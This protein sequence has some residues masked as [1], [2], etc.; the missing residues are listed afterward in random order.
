MASDDP[1]AA[2]PPR[3]EPPPGGAPSPDPGGEV[4]EALRGIA[5]RIDQLLDPGFRLLDHAERRIIEPVWRRVTRGEPRWPV[6]VAI[7]VAA[8]LQA[9]VPEWL[10]FGPRWLVPTMEGLAVLG[11]VAANP[12]RIDEESR[13][14]RSATVVL[15]GLITFGNVWSAGHLVQDLMSGDP[16]DISARHLLLTGAAI[17]LTNVIAFALWYWELDRGG[18]ASRAH[19]GRSHPDFLFPQMANPDLAPADW[20][21]QFVDYL[22]VSF[23]NATA[24]SP[25]DVVPLARWAKLT[26]LVQSLVSLTTLALVVARAVGLLDA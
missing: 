7:L 6:T 26:M 14:L 23:T 21:S 2:D 13:R 18:P 11:I 9:A 15:I 19:A 16:R 10:A 17:W 5:R 25:A 12:I 1:S 22:Y 20:N 4:P 24:F 3:R 8:G